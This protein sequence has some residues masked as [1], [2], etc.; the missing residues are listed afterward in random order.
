MDVKV[1]GK[2][3]DKKGCT[4]LKSRNLKG[5]TLNILN[6]VISSKCKSRTLAVLSANSHRRKKHD[7]APGK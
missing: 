3:K 6:C 4:L 7:S 2:G 5:F 1:A